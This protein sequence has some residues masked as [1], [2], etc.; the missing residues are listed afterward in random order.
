MLD[1]NRWMAVA[2]RYMQRTPLATDE[3]GQGMAEYG[4]VVVSI[5]IAAYAAFQYFGGEVSDMIGV[6]NTNIPAS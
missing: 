5:A 4:F 3:D 1:M 6:V 2:L